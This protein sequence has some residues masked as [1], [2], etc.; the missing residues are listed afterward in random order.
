MKIL[1]LII[2]FYFYDYSDFCNI[3]ELQGAY[4]WQISNRNFIRTIATTDRIFDR[5][6]HLDAMSSRY[7]FSSTL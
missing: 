5:I 2:S 7:R 3:F 1:L 4:Q 6:F